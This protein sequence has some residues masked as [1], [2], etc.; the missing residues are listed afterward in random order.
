MSKIRQQ[1]TAEQIRTILSE[2]FL[3]ELRDPRVQGLTILEVKI[4]RELQSA[5]I[6]VSALGN[7]NREEEVMAGLK[8]ASG[9]LRHELGQV[10]RLRT[11]PML[12]FHWDPSLSQAEHIHQLL[13]GLSKTETRPEE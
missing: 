1:R 4:D 13:D 3:R 8:S 11:V 2:L 9:F 7:D 6:Y 12:H 10:L 5:D